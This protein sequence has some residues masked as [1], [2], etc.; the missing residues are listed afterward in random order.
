MALKKNIANLDI[1]GNKYDVMFYPLLDRL[2]RIVQDINELFYNLEIC[3]S[4]DSFELLAAI[5]I[6]NKKIQFNREEL[7]D[8]IHHVRLKKPIDF[9][10]FDLVIIEASDSFGSK[11]FEDAGKS[12]GTRTIL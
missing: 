2:K 8:K 1:L 7:N 11:R 10:K 9:K 4:S 5:Y 6:E 3:I 12:F